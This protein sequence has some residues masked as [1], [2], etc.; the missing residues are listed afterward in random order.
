MPT[1]PYRNFP[2]LLIEHDP[3]A[4]SADKAD[5]KKHKVV[6]KRGFSGKY[7]HEV[8]ALLDKIASTKV[9][10]AL[11]SSLG[12][13][14]KDVKVRFPKLFVATYMKCNGGSPNTSKALG[15]P[16]REPIAAANPLPVLQQAARKSKLRAGSIASFIRSQRVIVPAVT[17]IDRLCA[18]ALAR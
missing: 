9:G 17:M 8:I 4:S 18:E 13:A 1:A 7:L 5:A 6:P 3:I 16:F 12:R 14:G 11:L 10:L 15:N 2:H